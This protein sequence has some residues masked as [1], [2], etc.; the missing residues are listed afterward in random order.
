MNERAVIR[1]RHVAQILI[2]GYGNELRGDDAAGVRVARAVATWE[3]PNVSVLAVP[4]LTPELAATLAGVEYAIF[5]DAG[6]G[7]AE[8]DFGVTPLA[9][10]AGGR[11]EGHTADPGSLLGLSETLYQRS[12]NAWLL[13]IPYASVDLGADLSTPTV[14]G[15][16]AVLR[17]L[18]DRLPR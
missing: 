15:V 14:R 6:P 17:Y 4:Q 5:V 3:L 16:L 13:T 1:E 18:R 2:V 7:S 8:V 12:P 10:C 9:P 11:L